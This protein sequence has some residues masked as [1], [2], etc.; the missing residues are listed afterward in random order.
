MRAWC[1]PAGCHAALLIDAAH[2][3]RRGASALIADYTVAPP[4]VYPLGGV[5][6][7]YNDEESVPGAP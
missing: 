3:S 5:T 2:H 7:M 1:T 6:A 4:G